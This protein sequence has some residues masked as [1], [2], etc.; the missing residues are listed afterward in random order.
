MKRVSFKVAKVLKEV[1]YPQEH[2][3]DKYVTEP[4]KGHYI[5][6]TSNPDCTSKDDDALYDF[7]I[8]EYVDHEMYSVSIAHSVTAP[9]YLDAW[10]WLWREKTIAIDCGCD[11]IGDNHWFSFITHLKTIKSGKDPEEAIK[12]AVNYI[13]ENNLIK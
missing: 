11:V 6:D 5:W 8:G 1:G 4:C 12:E 13:I 10:L 9:T 2:N 3:C 7:E